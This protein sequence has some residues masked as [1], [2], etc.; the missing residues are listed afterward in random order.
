MSDV[1]SQIEAY[2]IKRNIKEHEIELLKI[3]RK[4]FCNFS[5]SVLDIGCASGS[6]IELMASAYNHAEFTGFDIAGELIDAAKERKIA[7]KANFFVSDA[8]N[9]EPGRE[10]DIIIASGVM[11]IFNDFTVPLGKWLSWL[12]EGGKLYI[13]GRFNSENIDTIINFRNNSVQ[14][15]NWEGGLTS[16]STTTVLSYLE[17]RGLEGNFKRFHFPME[18][19]RD[20]GNPIRTYTIATNTGGNIVL[21]G[22][23]IIAEHFFLTVNNN[24]K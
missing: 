14:P 1:N 24:G 2:T 22:A 13:F 23:N 18:L 3:I 8:L 21:N 20:P 11:S 12:K 6:F 17:Q 5:G 4:D 7:A 15:A 19:D 16:Y 9:F 10:F